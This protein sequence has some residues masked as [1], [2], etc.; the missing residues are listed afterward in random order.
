MQ[1]MKIRHRILIFA[2]FC[3]ILAI[4]ADVQSQATNG[5]IEGSVRTANGAAVPNASLTIRNVDTGV[6]RRVQTD[7]F[8]RYRSP[9]LPLGNYEVSAE[10]TGFITTR[11]SGIVL[12]IAQTVNVS[13]DLKQAAGDLVTVADRQPIVEV[14]R[15]Q[16]GTTMDSRLLNNLPVRSRKFL[17]LGVLVPGATEFGDRDTSATADFSGVNHFYAN[18]LVDGVDAYQAWSNLPKAKFLV[19]YEFSQSA[20][21]EFQILSGNFNAEF[22]RSAGGLTNVVTRSGT[23]Q[24]HGDVSYY[25]GTS[26]LDATPRF[27]TTKPETREH[28]IG[29]SIGG[30]WIKDRLFIFGNADLQLRSEPMI[31]TSGTVLD[32]FDTTLASI[33]AAAE[34]ERFLQARSLVQSLTGDF[35]RDIDQYTT[36]VRADWYPNS[37]HSIMARF[38]YQNL[39]ATNVPENGFNTP[40]VS[41]TAVSNN[42]RVEVDNASLAIGWTSTLSTGWLNEARFQFSPGTE[43][44]IPNGEGPQVRIGSGRTGVAF[45][46]RDVL[47]ATLKE[48]RWQWQDNLTFIRGRH[49]WKAGVDIQRITDKSIGLTAGDGSYQFQ[50]LRDFANGR[51]NAY[52]QGFGVP[53]DTTTVPYYSFFVQ[54]N[55]RIRSNLSINLGVRYEFQ[56]LDQPS[57]S[58]PN[59]AQTARIPQD[60]NNWAPRIALAWQPIQKLVARASYGIHYG[61]LPLQVNSIAKTQNG[62]VQNLR[63]FR[64]QSAQGIVYPFVFPRDPNPQT[65]TP[66]ARIIVFDEDFVAPYVQQ[67]NLE[68]EREVLTDLSVSTG[69]LFT[70]ATR[71]RSNEDINLFPP[72]QRVFE[73][74]DTARN[75]F[76][77]FSLPSFGGPSSRPVP[78]FDQI[79]EFK[80]DNNSVYHAFFLQANKRYSRGLQ[81]LANYTWSKLI[82]RGAAPGNQINCCTSENP[83]NPGDERGL[84]R[85]DQ[86]HRANLATVWEV[87]RGWRAEAIVKL[88]SGRP[89][90]PTVTGDAGGDFNGNAV[91]GGDRAPFFGNSVFIGPGY[92]T[93]DAA[94]HKVFS[95][96]G[97][98]VDVGIE[99]YNLFNRSNYL[100]PA[101]EYYTFTNATSRLEGP[102]PSFGG[103][104]DATRSRTMQIVTRFSF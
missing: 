3:F 103:P 99:A 28:L 1:T 8:G 98:S 45:G 18:G 89:F 62:V 78:F 61:P 30:P 68:I 85:R 31:V 102:L 87:I 58:N 51:F 38:N 83:F 69:W 92:A 91:R 43:D 26:A 67:I 47:P 44:Q 73:I 10:R 75:I 54:D 40:I 22:G 71:L 66:G 5:V 17:D 33:T 32:G 95:W 57:V 81:L 94:V 88:G 41:G 104:I 50:S 79:A 52:T 76:G 21:R 74:R 9:L 72:G 16:P 34:R 82:D 100:R 70:K 36:L 64:G 56:D 7:M 15:K 93:V 80:S 13:F 12:Q 42:G 20:V 46:R 14:D 37:T 96:E 97:G 60:K 77:F 48:T 6:Q 2:A 49:E 4:G 35:E 63:E 24:W 23:N 59:F 84:G 86:E 55:F 27:A 29:G 11:R 25:L 53:E 19:P 101:P 65:P 39:R 90:T